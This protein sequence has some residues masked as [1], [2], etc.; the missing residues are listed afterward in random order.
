MATQSATGAERQPSSNNRFRH[1]HCHHRHRHRQRHQGHHACSMQL[2]PSSIG[3]G[4]TDGTQTE[5]KA[6]GAGIMW[7]QRP[8]ATNS[9]K[10]CVRA[11]MSIQSTQRRIYPSGINSI[12]H[13]AARVAYMHLRTINGD[14]LLHKRQQKGAQRIHL[15]NIHRHRHHKRHLNHQNHHPRRSLHRHSHRHI[16]HRN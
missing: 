10:K 9:I 5:S 12:A 6:V 13:L 2:R 14:V 11:C 15:R 4:W 8:I 3:P 16:H 1:R 7:I